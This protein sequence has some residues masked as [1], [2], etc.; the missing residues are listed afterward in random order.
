MRL[1][2]PTSYFDSPASREVAFPQNR[3][4]T[5]HA[6]RAEG[7]SPKITHIAMFAYAD[8]SCRE[9]DGSTWTLTQTS[10]RDD[11]RTSALP[12]HETHALGAW[13]GLA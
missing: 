5:T 9:F 8:G 7:A 11:E 10:R 6:L 1:A 12:S 3:D 2:P 4:L 13:N